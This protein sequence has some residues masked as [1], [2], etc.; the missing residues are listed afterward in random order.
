MDSTRFILGKVSG[1]LVVFQFMV[2]LL[3]ALVTEVVMTMM[4]LLVIFAPRTR[5]SLL[6]E[7]PASPF[8]RNFL[9]E[10]QSYFA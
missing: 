5:Q 3:S 8:L 2:S 7:V 4:F 9:S 10:C 1:V 6:H